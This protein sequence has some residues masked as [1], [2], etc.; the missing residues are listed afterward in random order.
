M[1]RATRIFASLVLLVFALSL[2][3]ATNPARGQLGG[4]PVG[5][6]ESERV[7]MPESAPAADTSSAKGERNVEAASS[8]SGKA[9]PAREPAEMAT[10]DVRTRQ[11]GDGRGA[12]SRLGM[13]EHSY[14]HGHCN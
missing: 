3:L 4:E 6:A 7:T 10:L 2:L 12:E 5:D 9:P 11:C 1:A 8:L 13:M 14:V